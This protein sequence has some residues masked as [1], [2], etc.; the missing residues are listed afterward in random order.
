MNC[1]AC[2]RVNLPPSQMPLH[3]VS[4]L[5]TDL[6]R[7]IVVL[8]LVLPH[9]VRFMNAATIS[10]ARFHGFSRARFLCLY[11]L[12]RPLQRIGA[13]FMACSPIR[14]RRGFER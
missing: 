13:E 3:H 11:T 5:L 4:M 6:G 1:N 10:R 9:K 8:D 2:Y 7:P 12:L 14:R